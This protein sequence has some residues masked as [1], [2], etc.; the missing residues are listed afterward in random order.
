MCLGVCLIQGLGRRPSCGE[1]TSTCNSKSWYSPCCSP[2]PCWKCQNHCWLQFPP[3]WPK[4]QCKQSCHLQR[5]NWKRYITQSLV[6]QIA[7]QRVL[8]TDDM[9]KMSSLRFS[10][11]CGPVLPH[12]QF[13]SR[14]S[15]LTN[16]VN[17]ILVFSLSSSQY[18][19][20]M[21]LCLAPDCTKERKER[22]L[23]P[24]TLILSLQL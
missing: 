7:Q 6:H 22:L 9:M 19:F 11:L 12:T 8:R 20:N 1:S 23:V 2:V 21:I 18:K 13:S 4:S 24:L 10:V 15:L 3:P 14:T 16:E 5:G 17:F